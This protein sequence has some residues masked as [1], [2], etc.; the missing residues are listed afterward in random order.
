MECT[1]NGYK[2]ENGEK[3]DADVIICATGFDT[4]FVPRFPILGRF[5][6]NLQDVWPRAPSSYF[7]VTVSDFPNYFMFLGPC[8]L[9][10]NGP[11]LAAIGQ[12]SALSVCRLTDT[13]DTQKPMQA[14]FWR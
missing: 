14:I 5:K 6:K 11:A 10:G 8:P 3:Y 9:V 4:P 1:E 7:G 12:C 13:D 2:T